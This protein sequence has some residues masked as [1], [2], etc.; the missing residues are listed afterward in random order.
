M[1]ENKPEMVMVEMSYLEEAG[2]NS[3][4]LGWR[5]RE[6]NRAMDAMFK[7]KYQEDDAKA[8]GQTTEGICE[9]NTRLVN[10]EADNIVLAKQ[11][12]GEVRKLDEALRE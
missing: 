5:R 9:T 10:A 8:M 2:K 7:G 4:E 6:M 11:I 1:S 3:V 12:L